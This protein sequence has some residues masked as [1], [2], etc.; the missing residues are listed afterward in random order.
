MNQ[1]GDAEQYT[2]H[3]FVHRY[4]DDVAG[5]IDMNGVESILDL[6]CGNGALTARFHDRGVS[7]TG[8]DASEEMLQIARSCLTA[9]R[10]LK[11]KTASLTGCACL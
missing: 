10:R 1:N 7:V 2:D 8:M 4:G 3:F 5:L 11:V 9:L 6:G